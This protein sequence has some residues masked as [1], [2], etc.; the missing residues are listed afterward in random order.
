ML[1]PL[2]L[3]SLA[4]AHSPSGLGLPGYGSAWSGAAQDGPL[5]LALDPSAAHPDKGAFLADAGLIRYRY[6]FQLDGEPP[7][8]DH[9]QDFLPYFAAAAPLGRVGIGLSGGLPYARSGSSERIGPQRFH[10]IV[11]RILLLEADLSL[12]WAVSDALTLGAALRA[13]QTRYRSTVAIDSGAMINGILGEQIAPVGEPLLEG[14]RAVEDARGAAWGFALGA[15]WRTP[16][17]L[18]LAGGFRSPMRT[19]VHGRISIVPSDDLRMALEGDLTARFAFPPE[20]FLGAAIPVGPLEID[21]DVGWI[22]WHT[23]AVVQQQVDGMVIT[24]DDVIVEDLLA[25]Y[26][27]DDPTLLGTLQ[28][29]GLYGLHDS[30]NAA[31]FGR[32]GFAPGWR[33]L[34]GAVWASPAISEGFVAPGNFDFTTVDARLGLAWAPTEHL[35]L[36]LTGDEILYKSRVVDDSVYAWDNGPEEGPALPCSNGRYWFHMARVGLAVMIGL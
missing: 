25:S 12:A 7:F 23:M 17:G 4:G 26:G 1:L 29:E 33:A 3:V 32:V 15:R 19:R 36:A 35:E 24:S 5:G 18:T 14:T 28:T 31:L 20:A 13:G 34:A 10:T 8:P 16:G 2:L 11:G 9:S 21:V 27:L 6:G 22:G 30:W